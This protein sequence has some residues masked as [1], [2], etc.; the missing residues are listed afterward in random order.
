MNKLIDGIKV[1]GEIKEE[2]KNEIDF[3]VSSGERRP[4]LTIVLVGKHSASKIYVKAKMK[5]CKEV[6]INAN[7]I[8]LNDNISEQDLLILIKK[9]NNKKT[10]D[11]FIVQLP[12]PDHISVQ[13]VI[14]SINS[15]KDIDGFTNDN[16]GSITS[17]KKKL[18]PATGLGVLTLIERYNIDIVSKN[19]VVLGSSRNVGAAIA[20]IL[21]QK[22]EVT[23]T[24]CNSKTKNLK[25]ITKNADIIISAVGK[26]NLVTQ[27]MVKDGVIIIDVGISRV[28]DST[29][30]S[31]YKIVGDVDFENVLKKA[32]MISP[33]P[34]GVGPMTIVSLLQN[35]LKAY[36]E[37]R[38][39]L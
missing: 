32:K 21:M 28:E 13:K 24:V 10:E 3:L 16:I 4:S 8:S 25:N 22:E 2:I 26:P 19:C 33:V 35:T 1:S 14:D 6:G 9:L 31:G 36:N 15:N 23:V 39:R 7:L 5:A 29:R 27:D 12:L 38:K 20:Q 11:G 17:K 18:M 37:N 30:K 34:G